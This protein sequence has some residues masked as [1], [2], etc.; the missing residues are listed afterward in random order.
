MAYRGKKQH[1]RYDNNSRRRRPVSRKIDI[2]GT[3]PAHVIVVPKRNENIER[4]I[5]RFIKKCKKAR[6]IEQYR[7]KEYYEKPSEKRR[8]MRLRRKSVIKKLNDERIKD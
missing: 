8:R 6:I 5:K 7:A 4:T 1:R 2:P 3:R